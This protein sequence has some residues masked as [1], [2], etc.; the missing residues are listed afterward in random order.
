MNPAINP[1]PIY[2]YSV[3]WQYCYIGLISST[4]C[5]TFGIAIFKWINTIY[6]DLFMVMIAYFM[7]IAF[8]SDY[9]VPVFPVW[10]DSFCHRILWTL[11]WWWHESYL[12]L[13]SSRNPVSVSHTVFATGYLFCK[14]V[15]AVM[16]V[17][18][19]CF[20]S[21]VSETGTY[22]SLSGHMSTEFSCWRHC[23]K[24][25]S[26]PAYGRSTPQ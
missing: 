21:D 3:A 12:Y 4:I 20:R 26:V 10:K 18:V 5:F 19:Y 23:T 16:L 11:P 6:S 13:M 1:K 9:D 22:R 15:S 7:Q 17:S 14:F 24:H 8:F 25:I 2:C